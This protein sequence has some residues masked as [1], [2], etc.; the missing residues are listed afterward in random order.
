M[1][2]I[3]QKRTE[4]LKQT[5]STD[6]LYIIESIE[7]LKIFI[8][9]EI[10][11]ITNKNITSNGKFLI[12]ET[13]FSK[14]YILFLAFLFMYLMYGCA[15]AP[16]TKEQKLQ[17][18]Q[19]LSSSQKVAVVS[20]MRPD[21]R[22]LGVQAEGIEIGVIASEQ[23]DKVPEFDVNH[24][25]KEAVVEWLDSH[26][27]PDI[28]LI[29]KAP[30]ISGDKVSAFLEQKRSE[31]YDSVVLISDFKAKDPG[32]KFVS[33]DGFG[34]SWPM[35]KFTILVNT[36]ASDP[37][38]YLNCKLAF[39]STNPDTEHFYLNYYSFKQI[40]LDLP[41]DIIGSVKQYGEMNPENKAKVIDGL[42]SIIQSSF[43]NWLQTWG[44]EG[45]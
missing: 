32:I 28:T 12:K 26:D 31:G 45:F 21:L 43:P 14:L 9:E 11:M 13:C 42:E 37:R 8:K 22:T 16:A 4:T 7:N 17:F 15:T 39:M 41:M 19:L 6:S 40:D 35:G 2:F 10:S 23:S 20:N 38:V 5:F 44:V 33:Y 25:L 29:E 1:D 30:D 3:N 24:L 34:L 27:V 36:V 18:N